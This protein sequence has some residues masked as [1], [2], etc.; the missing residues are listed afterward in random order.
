MIYVAL[1]VACALY[2][3][4]MHRSMEL[5]STL[6]DPNQRKNLLLRLIGFVAM[7]AWLHL[8]PLF[9]MT[10]YMRQ[11]GFL[12]TEV[13]LD[14]HVRAWIV[15]IYM[16]PTFLVI[17]WM[18]CLGPITASINGKLW[19]I[20]SKASLWGYAWAISPGIFMWATG[21]DT[22]P[23][24]FA[25]SA[26]LPFIIYITVTLTTPLE[27]QV[28]MWWLPFAVIVG[29]SILVSLAPARVQA[30]VAKELHHFGAGGGR[31]ALVKY[32]ESEVVGRAVLATKDAVY[33]RLGGND[34]W[35]SAHCLVRVPINDALYVVDLMGSAAREVRRRDTDRTD[36]LD[37]LA[38]ESD[39][40]F[41]R[42]D[43]I[44]EAGPGEDA[45][46]SLISPGSSAV[47]SGSTTMG[48]P[49]PSSASSKGSPTSP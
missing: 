13:L 30:L 20:R 9:M 5:A 25:A 6:R 24:I 37:M 33:I 47:A 12:A 17:M 10:V 23:F 34:D 49:A 22:G 29:E 8:L 41:C 36:I 40:R 1:F 7:S 2:V 26:S 19:S 44:T 3:F 48:P 4:G 21:A 31:F 39:R 35:Q 46:A 45:T 27:S 16:S 42:S 11:E 14:D 38:V 43:L 28:R 15:G 18:G 32:K